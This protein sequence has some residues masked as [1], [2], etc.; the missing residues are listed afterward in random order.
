MA[1]GVGYQIQ[2][3]AVLGY[4]ILFA[5][6]TVI[7]KNVE[8]KRQQDSLTI[9]MRNLINICF[10][11][12]INI[13]TLSFLGVAVNVLY[14]TDN[15]PYH[16]DGQ[17]YDLSHIVYCCLAAFILLVTTY[18]PFAG[19]LLFFSRNPFDKG[20]FSHPNRNY[21]I[22]KY[23][24][25]LLCVVYF[26][27]NSTLQLQFM[28]ILAAPALWGFYIFYHRINSLRS[29]NHRHFYKE[30]FL[31]SFIFFSFAIS[32]ILY[33]FSSQPYNY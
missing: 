28:F 21:I 24:I 13:F 30:L 6:A 15:S 18:F 16:P 17:C 31:E 22:S 12:S 33:N 14:C 20:P 23:I 5:I 2:I 27:L 7:T 32:C 26:A 11:F 19:G 29:S 8:Q 1:D 9:F 25:K 3:W 10:T 4:Y